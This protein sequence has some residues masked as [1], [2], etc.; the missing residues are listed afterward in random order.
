VNL[1]QVLGSLAA[2]LML[3]GCEQQEPLR[4]RTIVEPYKPEQKIAF[5]HEIHTKKNGIDCTYCH[6][7]TSTS[8]TDDLHLVN[9]CSNCHKQ[10]TG[11]SPVDTAAP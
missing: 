8:K 3:W 2:V 6:R 7:S 9:V 11:K 1:R 5:P 4:D 10:V